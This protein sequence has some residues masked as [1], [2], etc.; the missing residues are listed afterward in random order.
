LECARFTVARA[1][2]D[3]VSVFDNGMAL[4]PVRWISDGVLSALVHTRAS[5]RRAGQACSA[6]IDNLVLEG[7]S[8]GRGLG[9]MI[10]ASDRAVLVTSLWYVRDVDS[11]RLLV[12]GLTRDGV[13]LIER[14]EVAGALPDFRFTVSPVELLRRVTEVGRTEATLPR[15]WG[16]YFTRIAMPPLRVES[17]G[18]A[19]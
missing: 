3:R 6:E 8:G 9:D 19:T 14:G 18:I 16:D 10:A 11:E 12:T 7:A 2:D 1:S 15:E 13:Y 4:T 5:A 17:F